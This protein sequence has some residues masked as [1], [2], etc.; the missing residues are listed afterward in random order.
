MSE[1]ETICPYCG[2]G[3]RLQIDGQP[4]QRLSV[5]GVADSPANLGRIC[6][7]GS[8]LGQTVNVPDRPTRPMIRHD[9]RDDFQEVDWDTA[10]RFVAEITRYLLNAHGPDAIAC[11]GSGQL[12]TEPAY[13]I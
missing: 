3:C 1:R 8:L 9:R 11:Y 12:D 5:R 13:V 2:V 10:T 7:K 6:A 4:N